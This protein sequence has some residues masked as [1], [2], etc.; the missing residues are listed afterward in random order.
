[1]EAKGHERKGISEVMGREGKNRGRGGKR[2]GD[3][4]IIDLMHFSFQ[5]L[6]WQLF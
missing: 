5:K 2:K 3:G 6:F 4:S 1:M